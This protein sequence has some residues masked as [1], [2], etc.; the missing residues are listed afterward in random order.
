MSMVSLAAMPAGIDARSTDHTFMTLLL[1][2]C[3]GLV[4]SF[5][6]MAAGVDLSVA[7]I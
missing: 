5:S 7:I 2:G 6:L 3:V 1:F 4:A